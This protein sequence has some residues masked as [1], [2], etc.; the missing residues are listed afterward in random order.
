MQ[1]EINR[2]W[3]AKIIYKLC[4]EQMFL[5]TSFLHTQFLLHVQGLGWSDYEG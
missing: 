3:I 2:L 5:L 1:S 4:L